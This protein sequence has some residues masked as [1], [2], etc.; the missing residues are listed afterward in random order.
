MTTKLWKTTVSYLGDGLKHTCKKNN[1]II[2]K[3]DGIV[4]A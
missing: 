2:I 1:L 3:S 4:L